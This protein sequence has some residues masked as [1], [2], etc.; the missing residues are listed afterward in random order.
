MLTLIVC[1]VWTV[2]ITDVWTSL[3]SYS[4]LSYI[5][6]SC[7]LLCASCIF[8]RLFSFNLHMCTV[9]NLGGTSLPPSPVLNTNILTSTVSKMSFSGI[10]G[11]LEVRQY[12]VMNQIFPEVKVYKQVL[13]RLHCVNQNGREHNMFLQ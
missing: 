8:Y 4:L 10:L 6:L 12:T 3:P 11:I 5:F 13:L 1:I 7:P 9:S 2:K